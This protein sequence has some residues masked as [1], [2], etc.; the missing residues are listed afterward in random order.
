MKLVNLTIDGKNVQAAPGTSLR[1]T[2]RNLYEP[3]LQEK[4]TDMA[5]VMKVKLTETLRGRHAEKLL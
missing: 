1:G 2:C 4:E 5:F 3:Y